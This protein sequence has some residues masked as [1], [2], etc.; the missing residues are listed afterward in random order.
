MNGKDISRVLLVVFSVW[1]TAVAGVVPALGAVGGIGNTGVIGGTTQPPSGT[2]PAAP[3][4][5]KVSNFPGVLPVCL[6][7]NDNSTNETGFTVERS[8]DGGAFA[9]VGSVDA[10]VRTFNDDSVTKDMPYRYRVYANGILTKSG[11]SNEVEWVTP[12]YDPSGLEAK[13]NI[14]GGISLQWSR[15]NEHAA[16]KI[17]KE[18]HIPNQPAEVGVISLDN[19]QYYIDESVVAS[20]T[21]I[22]AVMAV[23]DAGSSRLSNTATVNFMAAPS[24]VVVQ[25]FPGTDELSVRWQDNTDNESMFVVEMAHSSQGAVS[26]NVPANTTEFVDQVWTDYFYMYR[27]KA[28]A[29]DGNYSPYSEVYSWYAPP[30][31][32][33][34]FKAEAV[35]G[36]EVKLT[37]TD[38]SKHETCFRI[39]RNGDNMIT[40][41]EVGANTTS[42]S[43][44]GLKPNTE[45][46]YTISAWNDVSKTKSE[47]YPFTKVTTPNGITK[48][49]G[50]LVK[51]SGLIAAGTKLDTVLQIGSPSMTVNGETREI[52][53]GKNTAPVIVGG[54]TLLPIRAVIEAYGGTVE[55]DGTARKV[56]VVCNGKTIELWIDSLN[57]KVNGESKTTEVAPQ[58]INERTMLPLRFISENLGLSVDWDGANQRVTIGT[59]S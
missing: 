16:Y 41:I 57:T 8:T 33:Q 24:N 35:S 25:H 23:N 55:W 53:P 14:A 39:T 45:Y 31:M 19:E 44:K 34:N 26:H 10:G 11:Y 2:A 32:P 6:E 37:W 9:K 50:G 43:D 12:P 20:G 51:N 13:V 28:V 38:L 59:G 18:S 3:T 21:Y 47:S 48:I 42:Y 52:D 5:L 40:P 58:I 36:S 56:T 4:E 30:Q 17:R 22:Y 15:N 54:R 29:A 1:L 46:S 49:Q 27:V 7:W